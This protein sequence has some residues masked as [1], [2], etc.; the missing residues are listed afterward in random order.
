MPT[1]RLPSFLPL[2]PEK[3]AASIDPRKASPAAPAHIDAL[4]HSLATGRHKGIGVGL[5]LTDGNTA[6][7][8]A[9]VPPSVLYLGVSG[10]IGGFG[11]VSIVS[12]ND[13]NA[14]VFTPAGNNTSVPT[15]LTYFSTSGIPGAVEQSP[16]KVRSDSLGSVPWTWTI[17]SFTVTFTTS[18]LGD[19]V[20]HSLAFHPVWLN[21]DID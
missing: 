6:T 4:Q 8:L 9:P 12:S 2:L 10:Y 15:G 5:Y 1:L 7:V 11:E 14:R 18:S 20:L 17:E 19:G 3:T 21:N 16:I 13:S